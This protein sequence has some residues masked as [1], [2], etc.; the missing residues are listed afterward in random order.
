[1]L[2]RVQDFFQRLII[3]A[4]NCSSNAV[5][6]SQADS[7]LREY[8]TGWNFGAGLKEF[9]GLLACG[10]P[11]LISIVSFTT[12]CRLAAHGF[13]HIKLG[14]V[15]DGRFLCVQK[16]IRIQFLFISVVNR[17]RNRKGGH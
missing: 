15:A 9:N 1:M 2:R 7:S 10:A 16:R 3:F 13:W 17:K 8:I 11:F 12:F 14:K 5:V 6:D 4:S